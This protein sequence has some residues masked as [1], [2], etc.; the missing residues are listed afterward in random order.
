MKKMQCQMNNFPIINN[1]IHNKQK[2]P[3]QETIL[4]NPLS[5]ITR[6]LHHVNN[7]NTIS[8]WIY[9]KQKTIQ[10]A[11]FNNYMAVYSSK[12]TKFIQI[13]AVILK[14]TIKKKNSKCYLFY[15]P[16]Q[17]RSPMSKQI[18]LNNIK[19]PRSEIR[20]YD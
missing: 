7:F 15:I 20:D 17:P 1:Q 3:I 13:T 14:K 19:Y 9:R 5:I 2:T 16:P 11:L 12:S 4:F 6:L 8:K 10:N 18:Q